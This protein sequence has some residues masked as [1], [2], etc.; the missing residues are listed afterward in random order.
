M[1]QI[2]SGMLPPLDI[3]GAFVRKTNLSSA[4]LRNANLAGADAS[5][6]LFR[7]SDFANANL[8]GTRLIGADLTGAKNLTIKQLRGAIIDETTKLPDYI[9]RDALA[10]R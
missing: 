1:N 10:G 3:R 2:D 5:G 7:G 4:N 8:K 9:S 6:A